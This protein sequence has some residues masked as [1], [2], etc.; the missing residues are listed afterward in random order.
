M[1][2][3]I[4]VTLTIHGSR[5]EITGTMT[6]RWNGNVYETFACANKIAERAAADEYAHWSDLSISVRLANGKPLPHRD[7]IAMEP[8]AAMTWSPIPF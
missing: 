8:R 1:Q 5:D 6:R 2:F 3:A 7:I 4:Y